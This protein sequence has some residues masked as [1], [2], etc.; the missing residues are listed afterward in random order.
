M[1]LLT[2]PAAVACLYTTVRNIDQAEKYF[3]FLPPH[4]RRLACGEELSFFGEISER[5]MN[6]GTPNERA[7]RSLEVALAGDATYSQVLV[8]KKTPSVHLYDTTLDETKILDLDNATLAAADPCWG[9][10]SSSSLLCD[11]VVAAG[12]EMF[13]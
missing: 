9:Q 11:E 4:G 3:G 7:K 6:W 12:P 10:Y 8:I 5:L 1:A 13:V 2:T